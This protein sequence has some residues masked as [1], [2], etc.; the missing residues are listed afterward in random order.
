MLTVDNIFGTAAS[1]YGLNEYA[2]DRIELNYTAHICKKGYTND[3]KLHNRINIF[4][5]FFRIDEDTD[6]SS[7]PLTLDALK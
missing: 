3:I 1:Y 2:F 4:V 6:V 7:I 5:L